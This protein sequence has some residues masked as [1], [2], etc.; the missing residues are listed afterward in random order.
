MK[1]RSAAGMKKESLNNV[2]NIHTAMDYDNEND[3]NESQSDS[4]L[5][6]DNLRISLN[7]TLF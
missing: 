4:D 3:I 7:K 1:K 2:L 6:T 5:N